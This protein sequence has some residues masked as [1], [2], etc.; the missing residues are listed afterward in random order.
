LG[1][2]TERTE[3]HLEEGIRVKD[4]E[5]LFHHLGLKEVKHLL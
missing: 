2:D 3:K 1:E 4:K 5:E